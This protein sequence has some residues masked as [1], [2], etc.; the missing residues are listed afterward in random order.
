MRVRRKKHLSERLAAVADVLYSPERTD[1]NYLTANLKK[2]YIDLR[3]VFKNDNPLYVEIGC[4]KGRFCAEYAKSH[5]DINILAVEV[6]A[7]VIVSACE[8]AKRE[9]I[10]N[11][12]FL[13][14]SG[15]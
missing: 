6:E 2:D 7:N 10:E 8:L 13:K 9:K 11:L 3:A 5:K 4:G 14:T 15:F 1:P 12:Y